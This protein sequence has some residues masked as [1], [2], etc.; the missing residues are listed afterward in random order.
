MDFLIALIKPV[1]ILLLFAAFMLFLVII[2][3]MLIYNLLEKND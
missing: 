2:L 1:I 3:S